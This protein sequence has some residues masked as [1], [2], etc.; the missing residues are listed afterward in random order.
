MS[1]KFALKWNDYQSNWKSSLSELHKDTN[2]A[3]VTLISD[4]KV[5]CSAHKVILSSCSNLFK[6][7]LKENSNANPLLYLCGVTSVNLDYILDYIYHGEV[8]LFQEQLD[9]FL[10]SAQKLEI[11]GLIGPEGTAEDTLHENEFYQEEENVIPSAQTKKKKKMNDNKEVITRRQNR[12]PPN[13]DASKI[14]VTSFTSEEIKERIKELYQRIDGVSSC[15]VCDYTSTYSSHV[16][17]HVEKHMD[18]LSYSCNLCNKEFR[19]IDSLSRHKSTIHRAKFS[20]PAI[21]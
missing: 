14:D 7:I 13:S 5:K 11:E 2:F 16:K 9:S 19:L 17:K 15:M 20:G 8:N 6:F 10:E 4:D 1:E 18:G 3:D 12:K 21:L